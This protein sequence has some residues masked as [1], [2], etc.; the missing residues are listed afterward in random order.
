MSPPKLVEISKYSLELEILLSE[1]F[2]A[3]DAEKHSR[4]LASRWE[5]QTVE[6]ILEPNQLNRVRPIL[7]ED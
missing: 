4:N 7:Y 5:R 3:C 1:C 6:K 2:S